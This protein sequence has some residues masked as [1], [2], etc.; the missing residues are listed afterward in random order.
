MTSN[1]KKAIGMLLAMQRH[2]W[3]QGIAMQAMY[4]AGEEEILI[5]MAYES[6]YRSLPD[7]RCAVIGV[8]DGAT[9]S[10]AV[11]EGLRKAYQL[12]NDEYLKT[13]LDNLL[14]WTRQEAARN[15][16]GILYHLTTGKQFWAD[17]VYM[18]PTFLAANKY[19]QEAVSAV[20][21][22]WDKL[23]DS[24]AQLMCHMWDEKG[25]TSEDFCDKS[26][27]GVGNGWTLVGIGKVISALPKEEYMEEINHLVQMELELLDSILKF[28]RK[29]GL[30]HNVVDDSSTF[31][32][33]NLSQMV[34]YTIYRG[35]NDGWM[36]SPYLIWAEL[37]RN[38]VQLC[39]DP[40][41][42]IHGVCGAPTFDKP[43]FA[44]EG[45][46]FYILM[47]QAREDYQA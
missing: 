36:P 18:V 20:S 11:G 32:E 39:V 30:F 25:D 26:H 21:G 38:A 37:L 29:D 45:Q 24:K 27:W 6:V 35:L 22:Y 10:C 1:M 34:A 41:G 43:G 47:E 31:V 15:E 33:T 40:V 2:S 46:A 13:G 3:E 28:V 12:C 17:S 19:Y 9:D 4:E 14:Q 42:R 8:M 23:Y 16:Q 7:G 44:P 5:Q